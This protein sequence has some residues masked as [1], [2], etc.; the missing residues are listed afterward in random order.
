MFNLKESATTT[1]AK[2][3]AIIRNI[4]R[5]L[6]VEALARMP[7]DS[8]LCSEIYQR[9]PSDAN[10]QMRLQETMELVIPQELTVTQN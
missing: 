3:Q 7:H 8:T 2:P 10:M 5:D 1:D 9:R 4:K 6:N